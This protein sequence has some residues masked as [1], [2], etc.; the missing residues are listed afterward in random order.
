MDACRARME[1]EDWGAYDAIFDVFRQLIESLSLRGQ[2]GGRKRAISR[3]RAQLR[4]FLTRCEAHSR[5]HPGVARVV[6][7]EMSGMAGSSVIRRLDKALRDVA[8]R[9]GLK[10]RSGV[11]SINSSRPDFRN[12]GNPMRQDVGRARPR[13]GGL[14][15]RGFDPLVDKCHRCKMVGHM[16]RDCKNPPMKAITYSV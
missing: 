13:R 4:E 6:F 5:K 15:K 10:N 7:G 2:S 8:S 14:T 11:E 3:V 9:D 16:I 12:S 1:G